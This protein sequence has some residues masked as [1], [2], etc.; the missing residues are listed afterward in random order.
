VTATGPDRPQ[1]D[2]PG[3]CRAV[4]HGVVDLQCPLPPGHDR[5]QDGTP[6]TWHGCEYSERREIDYGS[7]RHVIVITE[8]V[9][10]EPADH[11][12]EAVRH[13]MASRNRST[14]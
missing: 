14:S 1:E 9:T 2:G 7:A 11:V 6:G 4:K 5:E 13:I 10:W 12:A 3:K 8:T